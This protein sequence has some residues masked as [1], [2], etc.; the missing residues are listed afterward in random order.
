MEFTE[1]MLLK[2]VA[3]A[4]LAFLLGLFNLLPTGEQNGK[5]PDEDS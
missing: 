1:Y 3:L 4:V 2:L 5:Q